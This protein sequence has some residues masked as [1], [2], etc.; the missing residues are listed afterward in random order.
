MLHKYEDHKNYTVV[1]GKILFHF[2]LHASFSQIWSQSL[3]CTL[4]P[5]ALLA[6]AVAQN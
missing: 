1:H 6:L 5:K 3:L 2:E 4:L